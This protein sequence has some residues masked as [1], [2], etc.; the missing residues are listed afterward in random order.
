MDMLVA[1]RAMCDK[2]HI[3]Q[4]VLTEHVPAVNAMD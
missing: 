2:S 1:N 4:S 3:S